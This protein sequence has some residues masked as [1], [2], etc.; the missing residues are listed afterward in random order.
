MRHVA[1]LRF[2]GDEHRSNVA[3]M[4]T[5]TRSNLLTSLLLTVG[6]GVGGAVGV[7]GVACVKG[8]SPVPAAKADPKPTKQSI[9]VTLA[10]GTDNLHAGMMAMKIGAALLKEG[11]D[12]TLFVNLEAV[13]VADKRQPDGLRW[14]AGD[15]TIGGLYREFVTA[16]GKVLVCPHCAEAAGL[17]AADLREGAEIATVDQL[18]KLF[19]DADKVIDY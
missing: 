19:L 10:H 1:L 4:I 16:G 12:V 8:E 13:R 17:K 9:V 14:G 18:A 6:L 11:A 3:R 15:A 7:M 2:G 5:R